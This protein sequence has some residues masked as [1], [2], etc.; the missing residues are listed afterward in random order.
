MDE[1]HQKHSKAQTV[2][3]RQKQVYKSRHLS[4]R[5]KRKPIIIKLTKQRPTY[6]EDNKQHN[7]LQNKRQ[8]PN[9]PGSE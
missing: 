7:K 6:V 1:R 8:C 3:G 2:Q 4:K 9:K 5:R